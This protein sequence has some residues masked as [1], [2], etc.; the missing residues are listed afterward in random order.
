MMILGC[1]HNRDG[2]VLIACIKYNSITSTWFHVKEG[3]DQNTNL[4][5]KLTKLKI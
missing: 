4:F 1:P 5:Q 3:I 2:L